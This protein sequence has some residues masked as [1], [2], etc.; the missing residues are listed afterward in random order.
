M[1]RHAKL[2][3]LSF[4]DKE[5]PTVLGAVSTSDTQA[6]ASGIKIAFIGDSF[7]Y[8]LGIK[9][10]KDR[11]SD[12]VG[13]ELQ[14][15]YSNLE[16]YNLGTSGWNTIDEID[17]LIKNP[18]L[19][20]FNVLVFQFFLND[21]RSTHHKRLIKDEY[22]YNEFIDAI[23]SEPKNIVVRT[24]RSNS[25]FFDFMYNQSVKFYYAG[26]Y[27]FQK[28]LQ[29]MYD[30]SAAWENLTTQ[31]SKAKRYAKQNNAQLVFVI[32]PVMADLDK[33]YSLANY[34]NKITTYLSQNG[35]ESLDLYPAFKGY[36][37][38]KLTVNPFDQHPNEF[39]NRIAAREISSKLTEMLKQSP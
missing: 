9:N 13:Y 18:E 15:K 21:I 29:G 5:H 4:R 23:F 28:V 26:K 7:T 22:A 10:P 27:D 25:Y 6:S 30:D 17:Y 24:L 35:I 32:F 36:N 33:N 38:K 37:T 11:F 3:S 39:A 12:I 31:F 34:H 1:S 16:Y 19:P 2:N 14:S 8:G 20:K